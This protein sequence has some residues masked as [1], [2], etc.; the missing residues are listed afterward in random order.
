ME[1]CLKIRREANPECEFKVQRTASGPSLAAL[2]Q[3][4]SEESS[5]ARRAKPSAADGDR[6]RAG[7]HGALARKALPATYPAG[8][9]LN[10]LAY[11]SGRQHYG[12]A[13]GTATR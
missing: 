4:E 7:N 6:P 9:G 13:N 2:R 12:H 5:V 10:S 3:T 8:R 1:R 11:S